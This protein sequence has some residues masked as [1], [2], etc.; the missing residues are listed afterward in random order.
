MPSIPTQQSMNGKHATN[1]PRQPPLALHAPIQQPPVIQQQSVIQPQYRQTQ[2]ASYA[3]DGDPLPIVNSPGDHVSLATAVTNEDPIITS[4]QGP[5]N[6]SP[7]QFANYLGDGDSSIE[8]CRSL[9]GDTWN[10]IGEFR[11]AFDVRRDSLV[12]NGFLSDF[13]ELLNDPNI[14]MPVD[15]NQ[16][17]VSAVNMNGGYSSA[18]YMDTYSRTQP[19]QN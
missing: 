12:K 15:N 14:E 8:H 16:A 7:T 19:P 11:R 18:P 1:N 2:R 4:P 13:D 17:G 3:T 6:F 5:L 9:I 10:D